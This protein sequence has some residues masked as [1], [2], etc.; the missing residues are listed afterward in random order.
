MVSTTTPT[1]AYTCIQCGKD[2]NGG[3]IHQLTN[4]T[5]PP[6]SLDQARAELGLPP[7]DRRTTRKTQPVTQERFMAAIDEL[8]SAAR[9]WNGHG[10]E[11]LAKRAAVV[12]LLDEAGVK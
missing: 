10:P 1:S 5:W 8:T 11:F 2:E 3:D 6:L 9:A 7:T 12:A 4:H